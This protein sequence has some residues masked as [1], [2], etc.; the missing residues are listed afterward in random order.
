MKSSAALIAVVAVLLASFA[1]AAS[2]P[3]SDSSPIDYSAFGSFE[4]M[5]TSKYH[6][7]I[8]DRPGL[9]AQAGAG[10]YPNDGNLKSD[11]E[12]RRL[13]QQKLL[14]GPLEDFRPEVDPVRAY[15][16][17]VSHK[18]AAN[19]GLRLY[20]IARS[21]EEMGRLWQALK[22]YHAVVVHFPKSVS[23]Q[24]SSPWYIGVSALDA[25][26]R[27]LDEH[28]EWKLALVDAE[29]QI[30]NGWDKKATND[31]FR[32]NPG[33]WVEASV[34][35][36]E[37]PSAGRAKTMFERGN[38]RFV[39]W[40]NGDWQVRVNDRPFLIRGISYFPTPVG[41]SPD[42]GY[43]PHAD[44]MAAD[45]NRNQKADG[46]FDSFVDANGNNRQDADEP[47]IGDFRLLEDLGVNAVRLYHHGGNKELLRTLHRD[48]GI[49]VLM[50]DL[51][52]AYT[53]G[54]G[55]DWES[56]TDYGD[57]KQLE[58]MRESVRKMV[59]EHKD[60][61]YVLM[62]VL[63]N[64][65]NYGLGNNLRK[66]P[67][68]YYRFI[69]SLARMIHS[70][71]S[72]RP[73]AI[74]NGDLDFLDLISAEC[75]DVDVLAVNA[76]RGKNGMGE[77]FWSS[78][79]DIWKKPV[80]VSEFGC[81]A[82]NGEQSAEDAQNTQAAYLLSN[83]K[84]IERHSAGSKTGNAIGGVLFEFVDEWWKAGPSYEAA[85]QDKT[86]QTKG[87]FHG[88]W[89]YEEWLGL[90]TQ[91]SGESSPFLRQLRPSYLAFKSG[92]WSQ[93]LNFRTGQRVMNGDG[94]AREN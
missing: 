83:W 2:R 78:I 30:D 22:A 48:H 42:W 77:S 37:R 57:E 7:V 55:A 76:Y 66:N 10:V 40:N 17:W 13:V 79:R 31:S 43:K 6:Y 65:N 58:K 86:P 51:V 60:E 50:G 63:G 88:G 89:I 39:R 4:N 21:L 84:D 67:E 19:Q 62:W 61:D 34:A 93:P 81:P 52:G 41:R 47:A 73:V 74:C 69:N 1:F 85:V 18:G 14:E 29:V 24:D 46:P 56:G 94:E 92:P 53:I 5:G 33:T 8:K 9:A 11:P 20:N 59:K 68:A 87:P 12:Y 91:G 71:D 15:Y 26:H 38:V 90:T 3:A 70:L 75:G 49:K 23:W 27:L 36:R 35:A 64:E 82:Y 80:L 72:T 54:S 32:I 25:V 44:W 28:P 45:E 16:K